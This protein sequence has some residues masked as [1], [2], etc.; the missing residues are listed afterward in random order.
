MDVLPRRGV[1][2]ATA[3]VTPPESADPLQR[4][5]AAHRKQHA[6]AS[7]GTQL[8]RVLHEAIIRG[9]LA[10]G[11]RLSETEVASRLATS[12]QPVREAF[13]KLGEERLLTVLPQRGTFVSKIVVREVLEARLLR[14]II[15]VALVRKAAAEA[16]AALVLALRSNIARQRR[17]RASNRIGFLALDEEMHRL[18]VVRAAGEYA[19]R[20]DERI[21]AQID[22][23]RFLSYEA[24]TPIRQIV[25]EH[26]AIVEAIGARDPVAAAARMEQHLRELNKSLPVLVARLPAYFD[27]G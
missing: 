15:E 24:V 23:V 21:K 11:Q 8:H 3:E 6:P 27:V 13:I 10:P 18:I 5:A 22:R 17:M 4:L 7:M 26:A 12:R 19:W 2:A 1:P 9:E 16:D 14:E 25:A 20:V